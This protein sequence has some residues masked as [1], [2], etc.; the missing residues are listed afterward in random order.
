[1]RLIL[2]HFSNKCVHLAVQQTVNR[3]YKGR[4]SIKTTN[5]SS[6]EVKAVFE[7]ELSK[8]PL[9]LMQ[10]PELPQYSLISGNTLPTL[11]TSTRFYNGQTGTTELGWK[12]ASS[13]TLKKRSKNRVV[14]EKSFC[15]S[16]QEELHKYLFT[17]FSKDNSKDISEAVWK[18]ILCINSAIKP[19]IIEC[20]DASFQFKDICGLRCRIYNSKIEQLAEKLKVHDR[21]GIPEFNLDELKVQVTYDEESHKYTVIVKGEVFATCTYSYILSHKF[22][23]RFFKTHLSDMLTKADISQL[24]GS[25]LE[26]IAARQGDDTSLTIKSAYD[27]CELNIKKTTFYDILGTPQVALAVGMYLCV[28]QQATCID[29]SH[30]LAECPNLTQDRKLLIDML[31][32]L[33]LEDIIIQDGAVY[34]VTSAISH[35]VDVRGSGNDKTAERYAGDAKCEAP[36][37]NSQLKAHITYSLLDSCLVDLSVTEGTA[38]EHREIDLEYVKNNPKKL[39]IADRG[40]HALVTIINLLHLDAKF[41][42]RLNTKCSYSILK[43]TTDDGKDLSELVGLKL[44][45]TTVTKAIEQYGAIDFD[46]LP[47]GTP[48]RNSLTQEELERFGIADTTANQP[49]VRSDKPL[50]VVAV[51]R[52]D[53]SMV[54][55]DRIIYLGTS[56]L[57]D[58]ANTKAINLLYETRWAVEIA[59]KCLRQG[60]FLQKIKARNINT[61]KTCI[62]ASFV[63][64]AAKSNLYCRALGELGAELLI[65]F[66]V[67]DLSMIE[68]LDGIEKY[69]KAAQAGIPRRFME[70]MDV[71]RYFASRRHGRESCKYCF[72]DAITQKDLEFYNFYDRN[73]LME[74][75]LSDKQ[76][77]QLQDQSNAKFAFLDRRVTD[78]YAIVLAALEDDEE[79]KEELRQLED[80]FH[81]IGFKSDIFGV[82]EVIKAKCNSKN[83]TIKE[84]L[85][86]PLITPT[87]SLLCVMNEKGVFDIVASIFAPNDEVSYPGNR[88]EGANGAKDAEK[89]MNRAVARILKTCRTTS[90]PLKCFEKGS[91]YQ[92]TFR[93]LYQNV[94][95]TRHKFSC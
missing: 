66:D 24:F 27:N 56:L 85:T 65:D 60:C 93:L 77:E 12:V 52:D 69:T 72:P 23:H 80:G 54:K 70:I 61:V 16:S 30:R 46:V 33:G 84:A 50:R 68:D 74:P 11:Y 88:L 6:A 78:M 9:N 43:A 25:L 63:V 64:F 40:Y 55:K 59:I 90:I 8:A 10:I 89:T 51:H 45:S 42:I 19:H 39:L 17:E 47:A 13:Q 4:T 15:V 92:I 44:S 48:E 22:R 82:L 53:D 21:N 75:Q 3:L 35:E 49:T 29:N 37:D 57:S 5:A 71:I 38:T 20:I 34:K 73:R 67:S 95:R 14:E 94:N 81:S 18:M 26:I 31:V 83:L 86:R 41:I 76:L 1:M 7:A 91:S 79:A 2:L 58:K 62:Y 32:M 28:V 87:L 36:R